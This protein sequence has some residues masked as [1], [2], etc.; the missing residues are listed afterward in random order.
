MLRLLCWQGTWL[1]E[2]HV[3]VFCSCFPC[4]AIDDFV[5]LCFFVGNDFLPNLPSLDIREN[6]ME[7]IIQTYK[8]LLPSLGGYFCAGPEVQLFTHRNFREISSSVFMVELVCVAFVI[9]D[10]LLLLCVR[11]SL[12]VAPLALRSTGDA[13]GCFW[14][15]LVCKKIPPLRS[16][17]SNRSASRLPVCS[18]VFGFVNV[19]V[20]GLSS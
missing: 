3:C 19:C 7:K 13:W 4:V 12:N 5:F 9:T 15:R 16:E 1:T 18:L 8:K 20:S 17:P 2:T 6:A 11:V 14:Q 10:G